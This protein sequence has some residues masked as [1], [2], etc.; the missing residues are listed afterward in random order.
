MSLLPAVRTP[1]LV[2]LLAALVGVVAIVACGDGGNGLTGSVKI[3][4]S[5]TVFPIAE[6]MGEEFQ[7]LNRRV[8]LTVGIS[9]T[10]GG[11]KKFCRKETDITN[12]SRP[13]KASE[14]ETCA[15]NGVEFIELPIAIDG[16]SV[17]VNPKNDWVDHLT[18]EELKRIWEPASKVK[19]WSDVR[20]EWPDKRI[21]LVGP[22][23]DSGTFDYFTE[24]IVGEE[25]ASRPDFTA[26][27]DDNVLVQAIA[28]EENALGYFGYAF[29]VA[30][31]DK[32]KL[33]PIDSGNGPVAPTEQTVGDGTYQPLSRPL[34]IYISKRSVTEKPEVLEFVN[35]F[36]DEES[37]LLVEE[38]GYVTLT[39]EIYQL[40]RQRF[41]D[42][43]T[44][45]MFA[46]G[47]Q[48][49]V[50]LEELLSKR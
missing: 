44:G 26:S 32:L 18:V 35:F 46:G 19:R 13:I 7:L 6:A 47:S 25:G 14:V 37:G 10:G 39:S 36:L 16:L 11:F 42:R 40:V 20:P 45:S 4:G 15:D 2:I 28:G 24:A 1:Y 22:D 12:A 50:S 33:V 9:G 43:V 31:M 38:G 27:A 8:R 49:G 41:N 29:F 48:V 3:D 5:S 21:S 23:T 34:L 30:N 17:M